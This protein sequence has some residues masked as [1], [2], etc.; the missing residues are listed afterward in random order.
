MTLT[1]KSVAGLAAA[2]GLALLTSAASAQVTV[3]KY[4]P[5]TDNHTSDITFTGPVLATF[6]ESNNFF[7]TERNTIALFNSGTNYSGFQAFGLDVTGSFTVGAG[8]QT[9]TF[10]QKSDDGSYSFLSGPGLANNTPL[11]QIPGPTASSAGN[12]PI[13]KTLAAGTYNYEVKYSESNGA[14]GSLRFTTPVP[15]PSSV[16]SMG[17]GAVGLLG[18]VLRARKGKAK[19]LSA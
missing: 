8:G 9:F 6:T 1:L 17:L 14:P 10:R 5:A 12:S 11:I 2:A 7:D 13:T 16:A 3:T 18:L 19:R 4:G 15:E